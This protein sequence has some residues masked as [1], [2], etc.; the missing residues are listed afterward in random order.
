[1]PECLRQIE[2]WQFVQRR[3]GSVTS[4]RTPPH[5]QLPCT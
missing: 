2:Q 1:V 3:N 5:R 4:N